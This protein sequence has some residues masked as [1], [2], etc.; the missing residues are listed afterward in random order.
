MAL[1]A[2]KQAK[3]PPQPQQYYYTY[4]DQ[5]GKMVI[6]NLP[7][8]Y[9]K[10]KGY[11][12]IDVKSGPIKLAITNTQMSQ[13]LKS[14]ELIALVDQ[15]AADH[16]VDNWLVRAI[17]QAESAFYEK[18]KSNKGAMGL[19]QLIPATAR[20]FGVMDPFDPV[21]NITGGVKYLQWLIGHFD[22][23]FTKV[24]AAYNAGENAVKRYNG[25]PPFAETRAYVP[26]VKRLWE[27]KS[28]VPDPKAKGAMEYLNVGRG[29][30]QV[31]AETKP[32]NAN[33]A[34]TGT[35]QASAPPPM[36]S[37]EDANGR[38]TI[39]DKRPPKDARNVKVY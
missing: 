5:S 12:L 30:F 11:A 21:Q 1:D 13:V 18:A 32:Q 10:G 35:A 16:G 7:P 14:P 19:M 17:I 34:A 33:G 28:V 37:W 38:T 36:Y 9:M 31:N 3:R 23:D 15:I 8:D 26:K 2:Q 27:N 22:G 29:G 20:R 39:S 6:N 24:I 25:I 4:L